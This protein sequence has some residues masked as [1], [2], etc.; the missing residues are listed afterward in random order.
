MDKF[1][2]WHS[3]LQSNISISKQQVVRKTIESRRIEV[4]NEDEAEEELHIICKEIKEKWS[5]VMQGKFANN[6]LKVLFGRIFPGS[7]KAY[8]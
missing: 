8:S 1:H 3:L 7:E 5:M 4:L 6:R 2:L